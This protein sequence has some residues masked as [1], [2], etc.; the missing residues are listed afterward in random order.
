MHIRFI[1]GPISSNGFY[2]FTQTQFLEELPLGIFSIREKWELVLNAKTIQDRSFPF[3]GHSALPS[4]E[5]HPSE[6]WYIR[7]NLIPTEALVEKIKVL[8]VQTALYWK[9]E[10]I[11][12]AARIAVKNSSVEPPTSFKNIDSQL[13]EEEREWEQLHHVRHLFEWN[14]RQISHDFSLMAHYSFEDYEA[15]LIRGAEIKSKTSAGSAVVYGDHPVWVGEGVRL[16]CCTINTTNGPV[17]IGE[18]AY[19]MDGACLRGPIAIK[20]RSVVKMG[21]LLYEGTHIGKQCVVGGEIKNSTI[22]SYS[23][24]AHDGYLGDSVV[25]RWCNLGAGTTVSNVKNT[26]RPFSLP[27]PAI[28]WGKQKGLPKEIGEES[29]AFSSIK[30]LKTGVLM[31]DYVRTAIQTTLYS[32]SVVG[33]GAHLHGEHLPPHW[34]RPFCWGNK[35]EE[36]YELKKFIAHTKNWMALKNEELEEE[37]LKQIEYL[38]GLTEF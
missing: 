34:V 4:E 15:G 6:I 16:E 2:P 9:G 29:Q 10:K 3:S 37:E 22:Q 27:I 13:L 12:L 31:G 11:P 32:G 35:G 17:F 25:G 30:S 33:V 38:Y 24:K 23:N 1:E 21:A 5:L 36:Q 26:A 7:R 20:E 14:S 18:G 8:P 28:E 19:I